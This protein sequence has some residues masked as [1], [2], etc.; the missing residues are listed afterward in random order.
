MP[1]DLLE[2]KRGYMK[3][4]QNKAKETNII[5]GMLSF[6]SKKSKISTYKNH[7]I[8]KLLDNGIYNNIWN[9]YNQ[10][11]DDTEKDDEKILEY[12][13]ENE[14]EIRLLFDNI[15]PDKLETKKDDFFIQEIPLD[16]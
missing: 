11:L 15:E 16:L 12:L 6:V 4:A 2:R 14:I 13:N 5:R 10:Y 1:S 8:D 3:L 9:K 7:L